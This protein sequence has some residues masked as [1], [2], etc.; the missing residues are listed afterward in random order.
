MCVQG[1]VAWEGLFQCW[2]SHKHSLQ[3]IFIITL[4]SPTIAEESVLN[5]KLARGARL[6]SKFI[7]IFL[8]LLSLQLDGGE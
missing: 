7:S 3:Q 2:P 1:E 8:N 4:D 6:R 5:K